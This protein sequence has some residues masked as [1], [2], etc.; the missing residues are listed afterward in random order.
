MAVLSDKNSVLAARKIQKMLGEANSREQLNI[1][2][3]YFQ[4]FKAST[5]LSGLAEEAQKRINAREKELFPKHS[6]DKPI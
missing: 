1:I 2:K 3:R 4:L 6:H 5:P